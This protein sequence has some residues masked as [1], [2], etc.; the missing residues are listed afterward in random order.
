MERYEKVE[1]GY[2]MVRRQREVV[3]WWEG[4]REKGN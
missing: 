1:G 2:K 3:K 4:R